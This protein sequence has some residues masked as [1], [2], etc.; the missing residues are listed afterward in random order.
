MPASPTSGS[1]SRNTSR[2]SAPIPSRWGLP[3]AALLGAFHAQHALRLAAIGGKDSMSG[4]F[5]DLDVPPTLVAF[6]LAPGKASLALSPRVQT[7]RLHRLADRNPARCRQPARLRATQTGR[8]TTLI[9]STRKANSSPSTTSAAPASPPPSPKWPSA[10]ASALTERRTSR[11]ASSLSPSA[12]SP[13]SSSTPGR[14][15]PSAMPSYRPST[16]AT[17][18]REPVLVLNGETHSLTD[19]QA[20]WT[21]TLEPVYPTKAGDRRPQCADRSQ[22]MVAIEAHPPSS[23]IRIPHPQTATIRPQVVI[24]AFPGTNSEYDSAKAFREAGAEAEIL[25]F[26]NLTASHIEQSL[27]RPRGQDPPL[28]DPD[29]PRRLQRGRRTGRLRPSSSPPSS[30]VPRVA[31]AIMDLLHNR[32]GLVLG[33]CNGFQALIKTGLVPD[34][35]IG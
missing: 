7:S 16:S 29:V 14:R 23:P 25:V 30:A 12:T 32:D 33:I 1:P 28:A 21:A 10:T 26:R 13:S 9:N 11:S 5:N 8:R 17:P 22:I 34:G 24:P 4:S 31:E 35:R 3:F 18:P 2:N 6:A 20:A 27:D 15:I 19:L